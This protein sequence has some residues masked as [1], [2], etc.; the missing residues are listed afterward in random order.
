MSLIK[1]L[2][3]IR[4]WRQALPIALEGG[5]SEFCQWGKKDV[6]LPGFYPLISASTHYS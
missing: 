4:K 2:I 1:K 3:F 6:N 5:I